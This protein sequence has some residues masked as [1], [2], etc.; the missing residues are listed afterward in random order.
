MSDVLIARYSG[1]CANCDERYLEGTPIRRNADGWVHD[2]CR[3]FEPS[4]VRSGEV[5]CPDCFLIHPVG[6]CDR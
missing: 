3:V 6:K 2:N 4:T 5:A 1:W